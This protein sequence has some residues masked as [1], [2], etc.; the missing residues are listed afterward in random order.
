MIELTIPS[1]LDSSLCPEGHHVC[2]M[3][4]QYTSCTLKNGKKWNEQTKTEYANK[5][6]NHQ[7]QFP[8]AKQ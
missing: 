6:C 3:F 8:L 7:I 5:V 1:S 2:L 4:V